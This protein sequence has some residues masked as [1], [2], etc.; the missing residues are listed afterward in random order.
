MLILCFQIQVL[1]FAYSQVHYLLQATSRNNLYEHSI[2]T[3]NQS[4]VVVPKPRTE[5]C[6]ELFCYIGPVLWNILPIE[7]KFSVP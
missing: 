6:N 3:S 2:R 4:M 5:Q 1:L 7:L